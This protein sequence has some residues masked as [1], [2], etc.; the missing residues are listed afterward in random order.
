M[1]GFETV[2]LSAF[3][4]GAVCPVRCNPDFC[5]L[6]VIMKKWICTMLA[7]C[8]LFSLA[9][10]RNK[11][12][13]PAAP[14]TAVTFTDDL[15]REVTVDRPQRVACLAGSFA[16][17]WH[18]AGGTDTIM[19][20]ADDA[21]TW[22]DLTLGEN[23]V[24]LGGAKSLN[25]EQLA[26]CQPDF[27]LASCDTALEAE[28]EDMGLNVA[29]F[30]V[31]TFDDYLRMLNICTQITG[32]YENNDLYGEPVRAQIENAIVRADGAR[33]RVLCIC[34]T[35]SG[36]E[37]RNSEGNVLGEMMF[38]LD[39]I[40]IADRDE[41]LLEQLSLEA[42]RQADPDYIFLVLES[43][44]TAEA[45]QMLQTAL[46]SQPEWESL[47]AVK[48]KRFFILDSALYDL[49]PNAKWGDA[50]EALADILYPVQPE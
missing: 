38:D 39:C 13:E 43:G 25:V 40:N 33:P 28:L 2:F 10:C 50:Y 17:I 26:A 18:L 36:C 48:E 22:F 23:V 47:T 8:L 7:L 31:S 20:A 21:W 12:E 24:N 30:R 37:A 5:Y 19:A 49:E 4:E 1:K 41:S 35:G 45:E 15:G 44:E 14:G 6:E 27:V 16:D 3:W 34:V 29:Y 42:I 9:A 11:Q 46:L 32:C